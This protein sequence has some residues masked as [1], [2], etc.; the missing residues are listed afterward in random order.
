VKKGDLVRVVHNITTPYVEPGTIGTV[1]LDH[2]RIMVEDG[3]EMIF[4]FADG[5][6]FL[7]Y[8]KNLELVDAQD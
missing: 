3:L 5:K 7:E 1:I 2:P 8:C 6:Q 4:V